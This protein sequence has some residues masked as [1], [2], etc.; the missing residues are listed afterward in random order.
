MVWGAKEAPADP[1]VQ[2]SG[3]SA[4]RS[5]V[6]AASPEAI[7]VVGGGEPAGEAVKVQLGGHPALL[8]MNAYDADETLVIILVEDRLSVAE[9]V[10]VSAGLEALRRDAEAMG[11]AA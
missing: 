9:K 6:I 4:L 3:Y 10:S 1:P 2:F 7:S 8:L 5:L 11:V